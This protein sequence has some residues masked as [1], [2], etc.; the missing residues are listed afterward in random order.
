MN[1]AE[2]IELIRNSENS[3]LEFKLYDVPDHDLAKAL[4]AFLNLE[5]GTVLIGVEEGR[6][7]SAANRDRLEESI[8]DLCQCKIEPPVVPLLSWV[9]DI[10]PGQEVLAVCITRGPDKPYACVRGPRRTY[11]IRVGKKSREASREEIEMLHPPSGRLR[12][13]LEPVPGADLDALDQRRLRDYVSR[14]VDGTAPAEDDVVGW[15]TLLRSLGLMASS[16]RQLVATIDG[17][18]LFGRTPH[19][20]L[21]QAGIRA[22]SYPAREP[23][24]GTLADE[25]LRGPMV[26]LRA[27]NRSMVEAGLVE[28]AVDFVRRNA[29]PSHCPEGSRAVDRVDYPDEV[30]REAVVNAL[31]HR[32]YAIAGT[33]V[34]LTIFFDRLEITSP[35][36][37]PSTVTPEKMKAGLRYARNQTL[38][39]TMRDYGYVDPRGM[40]VRNK[41]IPGMRAHNG[42]EPE[43]IQEEHRFTV[44]LWKQARTAKPGRAVAST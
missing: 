26:A 3:G 4:T 25:H 43:L 21:R 16:A 35:G 7:T 40:G 37:L 2:L 20:Y 28:Q 44:R 22:V 24:G 10:E 15:E 17:V 8:S 13:G 42:T 19:R 32:D 30:V 34:M 12:Y 39:N 27:A 29:N 11:Y 5:G 36:C 9:R 23:E 1:R 33:G 14:V 41:I 18:L 31:V 6:S 38:V